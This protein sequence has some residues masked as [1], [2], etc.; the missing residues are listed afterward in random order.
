[1]DHHGNL[2]HLNTGPPVPRAAA[3]DRPQ[4]A[5]GWR[6]RAHVCARIALG[7]V[8]LAPSAAISQPDLLE[9]ERAFAFSARALDAQT[10]EARFTIAEGY[11]LYRDRMRFSTAPASLAAVPVLP[12]GTVKDDPFFGRVETYRGDVVVRLALAKPVPE[13]TV[14]V[15]AESQGRADAG[16]CYPPQAQKIWWMWKRA[17]KPRRESRA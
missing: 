7:A 12:R 11:Y 8:L 2:R 1:M 17:C 16:V 3:D 6:L 15:R 9:P 4:S 10:L 13:S 5:P 14:T